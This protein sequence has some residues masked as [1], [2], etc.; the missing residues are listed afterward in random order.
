MD[1]V[2]LAL[3]RALLSGDADVDALYQRARR[4][5]GRSWPWLRPLAR[6][7]R[8]DF[9]AGLSAADHDDLVRWLRAFPPLRHAFAGGAPVPEVRG[10]FPWHPTMATSPL[11]GLTLPALATP[12]DLAHWLGLSQAELD[13]LADP[14]GWGSGARSD[15]LRHYDY[16]WLPKR[17][18]GWRLIEAP[19]PRL[20]AIQRRILREILD[21]IPSHPAAHGGVRGRSAL[22]N[23]R[24]HLGSPMVLRLDLADFFPNIPGARVHALFTT[25]GYPAETARYLTGLTTHCAPAGLWRS[26]P[27]EPESP[28]AQRQSSRLWAKR[29]QD[30]HL[31]QGAPTSPALANLCAYR[32][33]LRLAGAAEASAARYT[34]YVD[35]LVFSCDYPSAAKARRLAQMAYGIIIEEGF[36]ANTRKTRLMSQAGAQRVTGLTVNVLPNL[37]RRHFDRL[38][39]ILTNCL[40]NGPAAENRQG[41]PDFEAYLR[42]HVAWAEQVHAVRGAKLR[43]LFDAIV[44]A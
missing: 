34:R 26:V 4:T 2:A 31:P 6:G 36:L 22:S 27:L 15:K 20:R 35:D 25:L 10:Y 29:F 19:K 32:L 33:D 18:G 42:G 14:A 24:M 5:L 28:P 41:R 43:A 12:G 1:K 44:W 16:R 7:V 11:P 39:A 38:K 21:P 40:H 13:W 17:S 9:G 23:A 8:R 3:A 30:R 37:D